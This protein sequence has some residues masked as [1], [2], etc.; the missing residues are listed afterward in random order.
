MSNMA[1]LPG[2]T[3]LGEIAQFG[4]H[5]QWV[6]RQRRVMVTQRVGRTN[7]EYGQDKRAG[8][9]PVFAFPIVKPFSSLR[10][11][12]HG[13]WLLDSPLQT[14]SGLYAIATAFVHMGLILKA[15]M[16]GCWIRFGL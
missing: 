12:T 15:V 8:M 6:R 13:W 2:G 4:G 9:D 14:V 11:S 1:V 16:F 10:N 7:I 5:V 3:E